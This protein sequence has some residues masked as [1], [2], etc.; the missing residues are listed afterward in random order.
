VTLTQAPEGWQATRAAMRDWN[1]ALREQGKRNETLWVV[2]QGE[3]TGMKHVHA[4]QWGDFIPKH[5][6]DESWPY[7]WNEIEGARAATDYLAKGVVRYVA[8]GLDQGGEA[9]EAH[10][11]LNGGRAAHWSRSFFGGMGRNAYRQANPLPGIYFVQTDRAGV[12][13]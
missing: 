9:L 5:M 3:E 2:E 12:R 7:G 11:N 1:R 10:M 6:L 8:K 13:A 4:V